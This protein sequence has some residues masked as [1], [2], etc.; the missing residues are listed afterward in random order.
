M[1]FRK[2]AEKVVATYAQRIND[3][4][5]ATYEAGITAA[6]EVLRSALTP[7]WTDTPE[8]LPEGA[9]KG[10]YAE[11]V[12]DDHHQLYSFTTSEVDMDDLAPK[13]TWEYMLL[14]AFDANGEVVK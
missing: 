2:L 1:D 5:D 3:D 6:T 9:V 11:R 14:A 4:R 8:P 13:G 12:L 7:T 10:I